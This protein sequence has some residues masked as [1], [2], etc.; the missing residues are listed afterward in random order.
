MKT[1]TTF[2]SFVLPGRQLSSLSF[3]YHAD[4][5]SFFFL[6]CNFP[7]FLFTT[8]HLSSLSVPQHAD[9]SFSYHAPF[10][11]YCSPTGRFLFPT[12][13][14]S[15]LSVPQH[16]GL[17]FSYHAPFFS[18]CSPTGRFLFPTMHLSSLS[19]PQQGDFFFL[20]CTFLLFLLPTT[21]RS[22]LSFFYHDRERKIPVPDFL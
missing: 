12:T 18:F 17:S 2:F 13:H 15:S 8:T 11:S 6:P 5:F 19:V 1:Y 4:F 16:A 9:L 21:Q 10:F 22:P 3:S 20:P 7:F 14:L